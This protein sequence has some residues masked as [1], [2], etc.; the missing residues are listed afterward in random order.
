MEKP[1]APFLLTLG[2]FT[3]FGILPEHVLKDVPPDQLTQHTFLEPS[4]SGGAFDLVKYATDQ[5]IEIKRSETYGGTKALLDRILMPIRTP[6]VAMTELETGSIDVMFLQTPDLDAAQKMTNVSIQSAQ[7]AGR[8]SIGVNISR[9]YLQDKRIRQAMMY[10]ID[11]KGIVKSIL[12]GEGEVVSTDIYGPD[13]MLP[14]EGINPYDFDPDK[15][16]QLMADVKW[17]PA[18]KLVITITPPNEDAWG[19]IVLQ[20]LRDVGFNAEMLQVDV[21]EYIRQLTDR[22][23]DLIL[24]GGGTFRADPN[25][26]ARNYTTANFAPAGGNWN[27]Y[28]NPEIDD[29]YAKGRETNDLAERKTIYTKVAQ[30]LNDELP[31]LY[32][33]SANS[34]YAVNNRVHGFKG[35]AYSDNRLWN[36]EE[37]FVDC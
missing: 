33:W 36:A 20:Q 32:M 9:P 26:S 18:Q 27:H 14:I 17:D 23:Y 13:W 28:S 15:A 3:G 2:N 4:V 10:A 24:G 34:L 5:Y 31:T 8:A 22:D 30:I 35:A 37:W 21:T 16:K 7:G 6:A 19:P 12:K 1:D 29:L 25:L 11:R